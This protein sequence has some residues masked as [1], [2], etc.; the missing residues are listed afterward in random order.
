MAR[1]PDGVD[2]A[3]LTVASRTVLL[4]AL[5]V[6]LVDH[7]PMRVAGLAAGDARMIEV[8]VAG[9]PALLVAKAYKIADRLRDA[10]MRPG[11]LSDKDAG[12]VLRLCLASDAYAVADSLAELSTDDRVGEAAR[13]GI[14]RLTS[15]FGRAR[16]A[17]V[18]MAVRAMQGSLEERLVRDVLTSFMAVINR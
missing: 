17:G 15:Q 12:D 6:A 14:E 5:E 3:S 2:L 9:V 16:S 11:R 4:D 7:A 1:V 13:I 10:T 8:N 18:E